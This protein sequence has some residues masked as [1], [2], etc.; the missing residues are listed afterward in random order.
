MIESTPSIIR[1]NMEIKIL[2]LTG[3]GERTALQGRPHTKV[4]EHVEKERERNSWAIAFTG[5]RTLSKQFS[6]REF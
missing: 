1:R 5:S 6:H 2:L 3:P 4:R